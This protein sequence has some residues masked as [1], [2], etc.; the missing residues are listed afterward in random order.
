MRDVVVPT[1]DDPFAVEDDL[2]DRRVVGAGECE[3]ARP[4]HAME[5]LTDDAAMRDHDDPLVGVCGGDASKR[6]PRA[7]VERFL[8]LRA[9]D[10]VPALLH[11]DLLEDRVAGGGATPE[12]ALL[13]I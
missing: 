2:A 3:P 13:P 1:Q 10:H 11:E 8:R 12:L 7:L 9:R 5:E 4:G 6:A